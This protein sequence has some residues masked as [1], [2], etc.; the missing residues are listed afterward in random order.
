[1]KKSKKNIKSVKEFCE[2]DF[3]NTR[4]VREIIALGGKLG[5][6]ETLDKNKKGKKTPGGNERQ[7]K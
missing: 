5:E 4:Q 3:E 1:M 2:E 6:E 7:K